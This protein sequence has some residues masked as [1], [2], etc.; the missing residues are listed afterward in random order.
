MIS[1]STSSRLPFLLV[2][3]LVPRLLSAQQ[4][5]EVHRSPDELLAA[6]NGEYQTPHGPV[7]AVGRDIAQVIT[8]PETYNP[9]DLT[10]FVDGLERLA[11][12]G[13]SEPVRTTAVMNLALLGSGRKQHPVGGMVDRLQRIY[14]RTNEPVVRSMVVTALSEVAERP[15]A[16]ALLRKVAVQ[17]PGQADF[18]GAASRALGTL[19]AMG[20]E[21]RAILR[22]LYETEAVKD[23]EAKLE[24]TNLAK[25]DY[26]IP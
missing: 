14:Y 25:Q 7:T 6:F 16:L 21:G 1:L 9:K 18:P 20:D 22:Q 10:R 8:H 12:K 24:L 11:L 5:R 4:G 23:P 19:V 15:N 2:L 13:V 17:Q 26:R 3:V